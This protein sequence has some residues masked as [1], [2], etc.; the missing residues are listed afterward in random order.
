M[1]DT[2]PSC[3]SPR[4]DTFT[5]HNLEDYR[6]LCGALWRQTFSPDDFHEVTDDQLMCQFAAGLFRRAEEVPE[7]RRRL[8]RATE[9]NLKLRHR[10]FLV[11]SIGKALEVLR[12]G[13]V[14][15]ST[16]DSAQERILENLY[17][18]LAELKEVT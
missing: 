5:A 6:Y 4:V 7:L 11:R 8:H 9:D 3:S 18:D 17:R 14:E 15:I 13:D 10:E 1:P 12:N 2:C 16:Y